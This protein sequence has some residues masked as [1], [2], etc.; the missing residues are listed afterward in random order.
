MPILPP[1]TLGILGGGQL[2]RMFVTA[3]RTMGYEV[4]VLDPDP[5]SPAGSMATEHLQKAYEDTAALDYL[6][7]KC[8]VI[9]TEFENIPVS[10]LQYLS[11]SC[12]VYP[13]ATALSITQNRIR[14]KSFI[15]SLGLQ[16]SPFIAIESEEDLADLSG[17]TFPAI[18][19]T[20]TLGYDGKGQVV[21]E[22]EQDVVQAFARIKVACVLEQ[23]INL[24]K[25]VSVVLA[26]DQ[27]GKTYCFPVAQ[28]EHV[29][30]VL[31]VSIAPA[32]LSAELRRQAL[33][34]AHKVA[35]GLDYCGVL[36]VE[37]FISTEGDLL[38][39]EIAPRPHNSGHFTLNACYSS[40][41]EQQLR[42]ICNLPPGNCDLHTPAAML[43]LLGDV[44]PQK[45]QPDWD[46]VLQIDRSSLHLY[47]KKEARAGRKM[48]HITF[49]AED[50]P[51][52][53]E[54]LKAAKAILAG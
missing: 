6:A 11:D 18:L 46:G 26:C 52:A 47:G 37:F 21:C 32:E 48:G 10:S 23:K 36:A 24:A 25:E 13:S 7:S 17:V 12:V 45:G 4:I 31:D 49:L 22:N 33:S 39:N 38:V 15:Q 41:F 1:S 9:T 51:A 53:L 29:N 19:K 42:M 27:G 40:Q 16:T 5:H 43:N 20:A 8:A 34:S 28:N 50:A 2:G 35:R 30:G 44:W 14:E 54:K 3:A